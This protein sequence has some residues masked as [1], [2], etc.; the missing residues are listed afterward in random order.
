VATPWQWN[1]FM[2]YTNQEVLGAVIGA[3]KGKSG[4]NATLTKLQND[5]VTYA[6]NQGFTVK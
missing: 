5:L 6:K 1:P 4:V 2:I 3:E